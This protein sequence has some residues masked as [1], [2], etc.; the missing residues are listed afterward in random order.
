M[1]RKVTTGLSVRILPSS[2][3]WI[4]VSSEVNNSDTL[5]KGVQG[6]ATDN[7]KK[8]LNNGIK[9]KKNFRFVDLHSHSIEQDGFY[10]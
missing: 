8:P 1:F 5:G 3:R 4:S 7:D 2:S 9:H 10:L 6:P